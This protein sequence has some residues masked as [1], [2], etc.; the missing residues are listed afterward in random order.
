MSTVRTTFDPR[1]W[2]V[3]P[4]QMI[5][6][7]QVMT[8]PRQ[9][10]PPA[11]IAHAADITATD[12]A[13]N[14]QYPIKLCA[15]SAQL[16]WLMDATKPSYCKCR[17]IGHPRGENQPEHHRRRNRPWS[18]TQPT[19]P[20]AEVPSARRHKDLSQ[21]SAMVVTLLQ[22]PHSNQAEKSCASSLCWRHLR[23]DDLHKHTR[24]TRRFGDQR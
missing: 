12:D 19:V 2:W 14:T 4:E 7:P 21:W 5:A 20:L 8:K 22:F 3:A 15:F 10:S 17:D 18:E 6:G 23:P 9:P 1:L 24:R 16:E 13:S 11:S